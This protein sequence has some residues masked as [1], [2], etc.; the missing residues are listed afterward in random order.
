MPGCKPGVF[1]LD[2]R[3]IVRVSEVRPGFEPGPR[4]FISATAVCLLPPFRSA[5]ALARAAETPADHQVIPDGVEPSITWVSSRRRSRW[6][7]GSLVATAL[8]TLAFGQACSVAS[9]QGGSRTH[10]I[11]RLSTWSLC[12]FAYPVIISRFAVVNR[13]NYRHRPSSS[14]VGLRPPLLVAGPGVAPD[15][16]GL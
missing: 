16:P 1:P 15:G 9:D 5:E 12:P 11:T 8:R 6:T 13:R 7:T 10:K 4:R 3:P 2:Q 14:F